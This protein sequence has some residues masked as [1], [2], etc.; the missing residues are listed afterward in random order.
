MHIRLALLMGVLVTG[1]LCL[2]ATPAAAV[3]WEPF[4]ARIYFATTNFSVSTVK[5]NT[6]YTAECAEA[7]IGTALI[8]GAPGSATWTGPARFVDCR[9]LGSGVPTSIAVTVSGTNAFD[10]LAETTALAGLEWPGGGTIETEIVLPIR[11]GCTIGIRPQQIMGGTFTAGADSHITA[12]RLKFNGQS[13]TISQSVAECATNVGIN[14][15]TLT[16]TWRV[17]NFDP[18]KPVTIT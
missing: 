14:T 18:L 8:A 2:N 7:S 17:M 13:V 15:A 3:V 12:S 5:N 4:G 11:P 10:V 16:A 1:V 6:V 9:R